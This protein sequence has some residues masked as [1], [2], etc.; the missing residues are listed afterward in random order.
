E[1]HR[2]SQELSRIKPRTRARSK[3]A[4][5]RKQE[6]TSF[7]ARDFEKAFRAGLRHQFRKAVLGWSGTAHFGSGLSRRTDFLT[8]RFR[9]GVRR[10]E[11]LFVCSVQLKGVPIATTCLEP[12]SDYGPG[13]FRIVRKP[14]WPVHFLR[15][16]CCRSV[17]SA[18]S[19]YRRLCPKAYSNM[20]RVRPRQSYAGC[21]QPKHPATELV[22]PGRSL[23]VP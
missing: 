13:A 10:E 21:V 19:S 11:S 14:I 17:G 12:L 3:A 20:T 9:S 22:R 1:T 5:P 6:A 2:G 16:P 15:L 23:L 18:H 7:A 4:S 8:R